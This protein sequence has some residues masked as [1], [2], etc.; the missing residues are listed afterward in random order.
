MNIQDKTYL[1]VIPESVPESLKELSTDLCIFSDSMLQ[2]WFAPLGGVNKSAKIAIYGI[3]PGWTQMK[4]AYKAEINRRNGAKK[5]L[6]KIAFAGS[7]RRNLVDMLDQLEI[8]KALDIENSNDLFQ[9]KLLHSSSILK[10]PVF[11]KGKNYTGSRPPLLKHPFLIKMLESV[12]VSE[13]QKLSNCLIIPLGKAANEG[14]NHVSESVNST[15]RILNG[16]PHPS[17]ANGHRV[18]QFKERKSALLAMIDK[19]DRNTA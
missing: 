4:A 10:Y 11:V 15:C 7:M 13:L 3:T 16:F 5:D 8:P 9:S 1:D 14:I 6:T 2:V 19:W 17:G 18:K 12:L